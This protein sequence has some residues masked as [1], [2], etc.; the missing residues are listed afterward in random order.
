MPSTLGTRVYG[1][2]RLRQKSRKPLEAPSSPGRVILLRSEWLATTLSLTWSGVASNWERPVRPAL[3]CHRDDAR[4][5]SL[6]SSHATADPPVRRR[7]RCAARH[8]DTELPYRRGAYERRTV[9]NESRCEDQVER[10]PHARPSRGRVGSAS[11]P[12]A[13]RRCAQ[14]CCPTCRE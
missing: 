4:M 12:N 8:H 2:S 14:Q 1:E 11:M 3:I 13:L 9:R 6:E 5:S 10:T 7:R